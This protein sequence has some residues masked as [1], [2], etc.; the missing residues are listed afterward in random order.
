MTTDTTKPKTIAEL[1]AA[2]AALSAEL[3]QRKATDDAASHFFD[4]NGQRITH[5]V[6]VNDALLRSMGIAME[7]RVQSIG[8][9]HAP[10][11]ANL[12][13][14]LASAISSAISSKNYVDAGLYLAA[15]H[16]KAAIASRLAQNTTAAD[17]PVAAEAA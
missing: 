16:A 9:L 15:L 3:A 13:T 7:R 2:H 14:A 11:E 5:T 12:E 6:E 8:D 10:D 1:E 17:D 4:A